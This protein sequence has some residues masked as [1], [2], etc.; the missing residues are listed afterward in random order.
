MRNKAGLLAAATGLA[1]SGGILLWAEERSRS[2][3]SERKVEA[4]EVPAAARAALQKLAGG[5]AITA[6]AEEIEHGRKYFEGSW[7]GPGGNVDALVTET[8]DLVELEETVPA[9]SV[10]AAVRIEIEKAAGKDAPVRYERKTYIAY[11]AHF[12]KDGKTRELLV[13][14]DG[15]RHREDDDDDDDKEADDD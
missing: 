2:E 9:D 6:Y 4:H 15:R 11:E 7:N 12:R 5:A 10:P 3:D 1:V 14:P 8:G 13:A